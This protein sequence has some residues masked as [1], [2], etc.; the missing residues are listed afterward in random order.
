[1]KTVEKGY[2]T[3]GRMCMFDRYH[4]LSIICFHDRRFMFYHYTA[5]HVDITDGDVLGCVIGLDLGR[6]S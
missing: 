4:Q 3:A 6:L 1:M 5:S 2:G